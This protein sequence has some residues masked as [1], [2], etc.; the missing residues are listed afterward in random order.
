MTLPAPT[1][2][3]MLPIDP[4]SRGASGK[5]PLALA[6]SQRQVAQA[7]PSDAVLGLEY[8]RT[9]VH[10]LYDCI[11][12]HFSDTRHSPWPRVAEWLYT[13][14]P[15]TRVLD[16]GCGNGK[17]MRLPRC[18]A[19]IEGCDMS[20]S[21]LDIC[22]ERNLIVRH[23]DCCALPHADESYDCALS[24]AVL[25]HLSTVDRR[26][27]AIREALRVIRKPQSI[28][29]ATAAAVSTT[30]QPMPASLDERIPPT[31]DA[32]TPAPPHSPDSAE[33]GQLL[34]CA[35]A[36]EQDES[37]RRRFAS[38]DV[39]VPWRKSG[40]THKPEDNQSSVQRY[41]HVYRVG[42]LEALFRAVGG[43]TIELSYFDRGNWAVRARRTSDAFNS[44][45]EAQRLFALWSQTSPDTGAPS[46]QTPQTSSS[47][48]KV[49]TA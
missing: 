29:Q 8:E 11:A 18:Q 14:Q 35:W 1:P 24:C 37:S 20:N 47:T 7:L 25:H 33:G 41:C 6:D 34:L 4:N 45:E 26:L 30:S 23:A 5:P 46:S 15:A 22:R 19:Q 13:L 36:Q 31:S 40:G 32:S 43:C 39:L 28:A 27:A 42:E 12:T 49:S 9:H 10:A 44:P 21:L 3:G 38:Q 17:Y 16:I 2:T 48:A